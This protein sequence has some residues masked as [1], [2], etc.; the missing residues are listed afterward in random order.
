MRGRPR[1]PVALHVVE[2]TF[3]PGRH[4]GQVENE[5]KPQGKL[6]KPAYLTGQAEKI[7][8]SVLP[9]CRGC[10]KLTAM[11]LPCGANY[12]CSS[13]LISAS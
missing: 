2:G 5:P 12:K 13:R 6:E 1:K 8:G 3:K 11:R 7:W 4:K 10:R 9:I